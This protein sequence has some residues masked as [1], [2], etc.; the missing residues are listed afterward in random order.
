MTIYRPWDFDVDMIQFERNGGFIGISGCWCVTEVDAD[1]REVEIAA[2]GHWV[3]GTCD[4]RG[5]TS[6]S[7]EELMMEGLEKLA[8]NCRIGDELH[9][10]HGDAAKG[11]VAKFVRI[12]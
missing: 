6:E 8:L 9:V 2:Q 7:V 11:E 3:R 4:A 12:A 10:P 1:N 5:M